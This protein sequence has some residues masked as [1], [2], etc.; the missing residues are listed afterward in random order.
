MTLVFGF[1]LLWADKRGLKE[2]DEFSINWKE[3]LFIGVLQAIALI[4][5]TSRSGITITGALIIGLSRQAAS[6]FSF[7]LS[8]PTIL[9]SGV[10]VTTNL[11]KHPLGIDWYSLFLGAILA[12]FAAYFCIHYFLKLIERLSMLPFVLYRLVLGGV[13]LG[14]LL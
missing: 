2:R 9:M 11:I 5:G 13:L 4:P 1:L 7:L 6:R 8:I 14:V 3:A 10:L 12:F